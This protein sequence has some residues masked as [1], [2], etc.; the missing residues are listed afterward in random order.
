MLPHCAGPPNARL[1]RACRQLIQV[2]KCGIQAADDDG[3]QIVEIMRDAARQLAD[4]FHLL[5]L[6]QRVFGLQA[7]RYR[8]GDPSFECLVELTQL[9]IGSLGGA[10][11]LQQLAFVT[12]SIGRVEDRDAREQMPRF[13]IASLDRIHEHR[14]TPSIL[15]GELQRDFVEETLH[16]QQRGEMRFEV[17]AA[18]D[19]QQVLQLPGVEIL[20]R[21]AGPPQKGG[22]D[23]QDTTARFQRQVTARRVLEQVFEVVGRRLTA[24]RSQARIAAIVSSGALRFGQCPVARIWTNVLPLR[25]W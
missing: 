13:A 4:R 8:V 1:F 23:A 20:C 6:T 14:K 7:L 3:Q 25:C 2:S 12:A 18:G 15:P 16:A 24:H 5:A 19:I 10:A 21:V 22:V 11:R 9:R 17:D